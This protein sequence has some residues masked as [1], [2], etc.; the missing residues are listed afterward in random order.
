LYNPDDNLAS[1]AIFHATN[2]VRK[3]KG[4]GVL[5]PNYELHMA[6]IA[7]IEAMQRH[8]FFGHFNEYDQDNRTIRQR[9]ENQ[10][11][12]FYIVAE[13]LARVHPF[14]LDAKHYRYRKGN[15]QYF[16]YGEN[17]QPLRPMTYGELGKSIVKDWLNS[18]GH[19]ENLL[20][21]EL[22]Y[23]GVAVEIDNNAYSSSQLPNVYAAQEF[24]TKYGDVEH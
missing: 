8:G 24:G 10:G 11:G 22:T 9:V 4:L 7:H 15:N 17:N 14:A 2:L 23:L 5:K 1:I 13:N 3:R 21:P 20:D 16:Y 12:H 19:R 18:K 6:G